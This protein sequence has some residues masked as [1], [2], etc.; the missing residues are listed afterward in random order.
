MEFCRHFTA[1]DAR[2]LFDEGFSLD[3]GFMFGVA[4]AAYQVEGGING[5]GEPLNNWVE[6]ERCGRVDTSGEAIR[7]WTDYPEQVEMASKMSLDA[8]RLGIEWARVQPV[9]SVKAS[10]TPEF[11]IKAIEAYSDMVASIM[12]AGMQP[13]VTLHHFTHPYWIAS[14]LWLSGRGLQLFE[15]YAEEVARRLNGFLVEKHGQAPVRYWITINEPNGLAFL[16]HLLGVFPHDA[17]GLGVTYQAWSNM[18]AGH[19]KA[20]DALHRVYEAEGWPSPMVTY[21]TI[22]FSTY[23]LDKVMTDML[24]ARRNG[25]ARGGLA[26]Y[27]EEGRRA[28]DAEIAKC[29]TVCKES[30]AGRVLERFAEKL[31]ARSL[32]A[33][34]FTSGIDAIYASEGPDRLDY[35]AVDFYDPFLRHYVKAPSLQDIREKRFNFNAEHWEWVLNPRA[36][37]HFLKAETINAEGLPLLIAENGLCH[38]VYGGRVE[39]RHDGATRDVFLQSF[40]FEALRAMKDGVP[41]IGYL[42]WSMVDNYEWGSYDPRFGLFTVDRSRS[43]IKVSSVDAWGTDAAG[44]YAGLIDALRSGDRERM[45]SAFTSDSW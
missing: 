6:F 10:G 40:L 45:V 15:K 4:N 26:E 21:N 11:D 7:F 5:H 3:D 18:V 17:R 44:A 13:V 43:P 39:Q 36:M 25:V 16:V 30:L 27:L 2:T 12:R 19:C 8:F 31:S 28:W 23:G 42:Y 41:L 24:N 33:S 32:D 38:K 14:D 35:L 9:T 22:N 37:Y 29:P 20:Y 34:R 1:R